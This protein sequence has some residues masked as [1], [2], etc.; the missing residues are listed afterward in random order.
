MRFRLH[1]HAFALIY[2]SLAGCH[3]NNTTTSTSLFKDERSMQDALK[4]S[5]IL[6]E[7][8]DSIDSGLTPKLLEYML[9]KKHSLAYYPDHKNGDADPT[10]LVYL[11]QNKNALE[12]QVIADF[13]YAE[14]K[15]LLFSE[16]IKLAG[17]KPQKIAT[18][19]FIISPSDTILRLYSDSTP[20]SHIDLIKYDNSNCIHTAAYSHI[21]NSKFIAGKYF[22]I[23]DTGKIRHIIFTKC[24]NLEGVENIDASLSGHSQFEVTITN[25]YTNPD[26]I[27]FFDPKFDKGQIFNWQVIQD[28]LILYHDGNAKDN[29]IV[30]VKAL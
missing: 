23:D 27:E 1:F 22:R 19:E 7:Y 5:W 15:I 10:H 29:R 28:S 20:D 17:Q 24:G 11:W 12:D 3:T 13:R 25:F 26:A 21:I 2:L 4:G 8:A 9:D 16:T 14:N 6:Q 18:A 30:L